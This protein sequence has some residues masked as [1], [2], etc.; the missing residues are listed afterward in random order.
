MTIT[1]DALIEQLS[2]DLQPVG[3]FAI[4]GRIALGLALGVL[5]AMLTVT[6]LLG[7]RPDLGTAMHGFSFWMKWTYTATIGLGAAYAVSRLAY[8]DVRSLRPLWLLAVPVLLLAGVA[9]GE[10]ATTPS[11]DWVGMWLGK[12]WAGCP[13]LVLLFSAPIFLGLLWSFRNLAP[14]R[15]RAAG[16][17]AGLAAGAWSATAYCLHCPD[18]S[19]LFVLTWYSLGIALAA[20]IG[21]LI[22]PRLLRW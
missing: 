12:S 20:G 8:P 19:A 15:L 14:T 18:I 1:T 13:W 16:A 6:V 21:A 22:G 2:S 17:V 11:A 9:I 3:R 10:L 7:V 4:A 5:A